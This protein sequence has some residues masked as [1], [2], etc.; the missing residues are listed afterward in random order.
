[1]YVLLSHFVAQFF[2]VTGSRTNLNFR[3]HGLLKY[4]KVKV[5]F[6]KYIY[7]IF[8]EAQERVRLFYRVQWIS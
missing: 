2:E 5:Y 3:E 4:L 1:M 6:K 8:N 7:C